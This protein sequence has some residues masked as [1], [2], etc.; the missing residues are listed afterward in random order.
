MSSRSVRRITQSALY[1]SFNP[2][3]SPEGGR[4]I[5]FL[6]KA[7]NHDQIYLSDPYGTTQT[8]LTNDTTT[9]NFYPSWISGDEII[10]SRSPGKLMQMDLK[11][12]SIAVLGLYGSNW[13]RYNSRINKLACVTRQPDAKLIMLDYKEKTEK[14]V[15]AVSA[16]QNLF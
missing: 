5:Y 3:W 14:N 12:N 16:L 10:F 4:I 6:E 1:S 7:D 8:N 15:I 11:L 2:V 13:A 9:L